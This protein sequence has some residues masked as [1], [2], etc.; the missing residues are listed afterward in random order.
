MK[1]IQFEGVNV[2]FAKNQPPYIPLPA[3]RDGGPA[4]TVTTC[5]QLTWRE[6]LQV[7]FSGIV[8]HQT[9]TFHKPLCPIRLMSSRP[10]LP[11]ATP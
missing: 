11:G 4:G 8:W 1:P 2:T 6:R 9:M 3:H 10:D 7:L 5:W